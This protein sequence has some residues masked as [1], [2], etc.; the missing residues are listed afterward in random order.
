MDLKLKYNTKNEG[1]TV[2]PG[3]VEK[4]KLIFVLIP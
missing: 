3:K 2:E 1:K 4:R